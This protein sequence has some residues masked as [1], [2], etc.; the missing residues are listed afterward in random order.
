MC[1][2]LFAHRTPTGGGGEDILFCVRQKMKFVYNSEEIKPSSVHAIDQVASRCPRT[3]YRECA[4]RYLAI[5]CETDDE[6]SGNVAEF[7]P[8]ISASLISTIPIMLY[9]HFHLIAI[10]IRR[11]TRY[12][13][14]R[15]GF[16]T[17][18][19]P[20]FPHSPRST[21]RQNLTFC[22]RGTGT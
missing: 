20:E 13:V 1:L 2:P 3:S 10:L 14:E 8:S 17:L 7:Y 9:T 12:E 22:A 16:E 11:T 6:R 21:I 5:S 19:G 18:S 4:G 15:S